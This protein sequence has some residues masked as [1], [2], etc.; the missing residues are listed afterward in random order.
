MR[1]TVAMLVLAVLLAGCSGAGDGGDSNA[2]ASPATTQATATGTIDGMFDVGGHKL[3]LECQGSGSP[4]LVYLHGLGGN[5]EGAASI[6]APLTDR[7][8]VCVYDRLNAGRSD[9]EGDRHTGADSVQD[10]HALLDAAAVRGPYLLLGFSFSGLLA[11]MYAGTYPNQVMGI[12]LLDSSL[13][14]DAEVDQ[15]IPKAER[16]QAVAEGEANPE[17]VEFY[18]T[19]DQAKALVGKVPDVPVTYMAA[20]PVDLPSTWPVKR[21]RAFIRTQQTEFVGR[22]RQGRLVRVRSPHDI[23][24]AMPGRVLQ[25]VEKILSSS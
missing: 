15:L 1:R 7:I 10:L 20:E 11:T 8:R 12:L 19:L 16:A 6:Y 25:E 17:R 2:T 14:T 5:S 13:P 18:R 24:L 9:S 21:M 3:H 22:F 4:T 23:D